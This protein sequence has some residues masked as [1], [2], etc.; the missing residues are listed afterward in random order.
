MSTASQSAWLKMSSDRP[1]EFFF[2]RSLGKR[3]A[4]ALVEAGWVIHLIADHY[5][6]DA[7]HV[8]DVAWIEDGCR[9]GWALL[10]KDQRIRYR[11]QELAALNGLL[12][13]LSSGNLGLDEMAHRFLAAKPAIDRIISREKLG[14]WLVYD[15]GRVEKRWP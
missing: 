15:E 3:S 6:D 9:R 13:C 1:R 11:A 2:D 5:P 4:N 12:F 10:T 7:A 14:F 8:S